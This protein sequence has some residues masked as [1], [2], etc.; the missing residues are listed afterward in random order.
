MLAVAQTV[1]QLADQPQVHPAHLAEA[2]QYRPRIPPMVEL[3][4]PGQL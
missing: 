1:A 4:E 3:L 2:I